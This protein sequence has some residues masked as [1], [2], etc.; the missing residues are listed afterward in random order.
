MLVVWHSAKTAATKK[1]R[2]TSLRR[3]A[4]RGPQGSSSQAAIKAT[5]AT[6]TVTKPKRRP[7]SRRSKAQVARAPASALQNRR[8]KIPGRREAPTL[9]GKGAVTLA[10]RSH[11]RMRSLFEAVLCI[12][13]AMP[14]FT[15]V[16]PDV[17]LPPV[18]PSGTPGRYP[19]NALRYR[20][21]APECPGELP[22]ATR[23]VLRKCLA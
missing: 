13:E 4:V 22:E 23:E 9:C 18:T 1:Q 15:T 12:P 8:T 14:H 7:S 6:V 21:H 10:S 2:A 20:C 16:R 5:A 19:S 11:A 3:V 17:H